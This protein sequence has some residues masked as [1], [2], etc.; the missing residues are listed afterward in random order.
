M[1]KSPIHDCHLT[2]D[3]IVFAFLRSRVNI[4]QI[5]GEYPAMMQYG[6]LGKSLFF[7]ITWAISPR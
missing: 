6:G 1:S 2:W 4:M 7:P 3:E 5:P